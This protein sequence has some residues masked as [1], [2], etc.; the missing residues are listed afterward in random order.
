MLGTCPLPMFDSPGLRHRF[1]K[2]RVASSHYAS[3]EA[4]EEL[5]IYVFR[6][7][8]ELAVSLENDLPD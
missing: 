4:I 8:S 5:R 7:A 2:N 1:S 3:M 6:P